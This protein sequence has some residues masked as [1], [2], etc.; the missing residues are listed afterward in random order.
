MAT[1][2]EEIQHIIKRNL[3]QAP[4]RGGDLLVAVIPVRVIRYICGS[5]LY[6]RYDL[7]CFLKSAEEN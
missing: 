7:C 1:I 6:L 4:D 5:S 3:E 2:V